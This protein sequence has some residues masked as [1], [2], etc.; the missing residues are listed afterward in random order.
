LTT[1]GFWRN[2][3]FIA[4]FVETYNLNKLK[5]DRLDFSFAYVYNKFQLIASHYMNKSIT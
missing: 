5:L 2:E 3:Q 4:N 1:R